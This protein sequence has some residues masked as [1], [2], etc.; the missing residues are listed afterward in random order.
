MSPAFVQKISR[1][2][3][4]AAVIRLWPRWCAAIGLLTSVAL[5]AGC[6]GAPDDRSLRDSF[7][8]QVASV[9]LVKDFRRS[10][11]EL[12]FS[13]AYGNVADATWRIVL[14][15]AA[16]E[17]NPDPAQPYK[18]LVKS[19]WYVNDEKIEPRGSYSDLPSEFLD[20]GLGQ[21]CW[22]FWNPTTKRWE[23]V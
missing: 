3:P 22:A 15:S 1:A 8:D 23:W 6:G 2:R 18:G 11:D 17:P 10:G 14:E 20:S 5:V 9:S 12:R 4:G 16:I 19:A 7:S 21:E 13:G